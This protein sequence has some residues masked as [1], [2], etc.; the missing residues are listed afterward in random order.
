M[1]NSKRKINFSAGPAMLPQ[2]VMQQIEDE[3]WDY[4]GTGVSIMEMG[5]RTPLFDDL[6][7]DTENK[8]RQ[9]LNIPQNYHVLFTHGGASH[10]FPTIPLNLLSQGEKADYLVTGIWSKKS[11][12]EASRLGD[13]NAID[14][15]IN[16]N[17]NRGIASLADL[18]LREG[19]KYLYYCP[20]ETVAGLAYN[21][22]PN[23]NGNLVA[24]Y[25]SAIMAEP[26]DVSRYGLIFAGAQKNLGIAG[27][28]LVIVRDDLLTEM[29]AD[30]PVLWHYKTMIDER[31][32][33][34]TPPTFAWYVS[35]LMVSW[36]VEQGGLEH[37]KQKNHAN[38]DMLYG[39]V[40][41]SDFYFN[42]VVLANRSLLNVPFILQNESLNDE[43]L[44]Q[45]E[46]AGMTALKGHR[47]VGGMRASMYNAMPTEA[48]SQLIDFMQTF[49]NKYQ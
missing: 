27:I 9:L 44:Q 28:T 43:F 16:Q 45:A 39:F 26:I 14:A 40:D 19:I 25:T 8:V 22:I 23:F 37:F 49:A 48:V 12:E 18:Q 17:G 24:D 11:A 30:L 29:P 47:S 42:D 35:N 46:L 13:V 32:L 2:A 4:K 15:V 6:V 31:G 20:N 7:V 36:M 34:N 10:Q 5:H 38:A 1:S 3:L 33:Y 41:Q 21:D